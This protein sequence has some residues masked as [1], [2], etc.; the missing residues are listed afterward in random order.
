MS[1]ITRLNDFRAAPGKE[2]DLRDF[3][4]SIIGLIRDAPG[5]RDVAL[6]LDQ[7]DAAHFVIVEEWDSVDAHKASVS[8]I[9][10]GKIGEVRNLIASPPV[11]RYYDPA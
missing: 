6:L 1:I 7:E 3:L 9:P 11:G 5:C 2:T 8:R 10:P 4:K